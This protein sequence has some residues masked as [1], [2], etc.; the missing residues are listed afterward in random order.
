MSL[1]NLQQH[2][3][4]VMY[5]LLVLLLWWHLNAYLWHVKTIL[6]QHFYWHSF[7]KVV[8]KTIDITHFPNVTCR[9]IGGLVAIAAHPQPLRA[10]WHCA[11]VSVSVID[12][13]GLTELT[14]HHSP[15]TDQGKC[16]CLGF[17][18]S[19]YPS[20]NPPLLPTPFAYG[21]GKQKLCSMMEV[22]IDP[23]RRW[24]WNT[25]GV[26]R[27]NVAVT[28]GWGGVSGFSLAVCKLIAFCLL[29]YTL[30]LT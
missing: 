10:T 21:R 29:Y 11:S 18:L 30:A 3:W 13:D 9:H 6:K 2:T 27:I 1:D 23:A 20:P 19:I 25:N 12:R 5:L 26:N 24:G 4:E 22:C 15:Y 14:G 8:L 16:H 7:Q 17:Y 28:L